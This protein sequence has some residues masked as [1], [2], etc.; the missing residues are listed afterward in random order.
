MSTGKPTHMRVGLK[1]RNA[2]ITLE[3]RWDRAPRICAAIAERLPI[4]GPVWHA[5]YANNEIYTL[6]PAFDPAPPQEWLC[7]YPA[8]GDLMYI[9]IPPGVPLPPGAVE[10]DMT[11]GV[12]D[13]AYFYDRGNSLL[14]GPSGP[15]VGSIFA[16]A[17]SLDDI[18]A[19][20]KD[21]NDVCRGGSVGEML[22]LEAM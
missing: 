14:H 12:L 2:C 9:P 10:M 8:P 20:A 5:K 18:W 22:E 15:V 13:L 19:F 4:R 11:R 7:A 21:C 16:T 6:V 1:R 17:T 3:L